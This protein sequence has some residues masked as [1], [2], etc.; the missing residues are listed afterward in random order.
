MRLD[1]DSVKTEKSTF[2]YGEQHI[3]APGRVRSVIWNGCDQQNDGHHHSQI[4]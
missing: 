4:N 1:R 3:E 2:S